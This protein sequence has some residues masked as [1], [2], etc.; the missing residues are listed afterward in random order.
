MQ[1]KNRLIRITENQLKEAESFNFLNGTSEPHCDGQSA[2]SADGRLNDDEYGQPET[3]DDIADTVSPQAYLR[4][5]DKSHGINGIR[6]IWESDEDLNDDG[7]NDFT[8][9]PDKDLLND[10]NFANDITR[11]PPTVI[12]KLNLFLNEIAKHNL[13]ERK[14]YIILSHILK[15]LGLHSLPPS[16]KKDLRNTIN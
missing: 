16:Y 3:T 13:T 12:Q 6:R 2:I 11:I 14:K 1:R 4:Y 5:F 7:A 15:V 9:K 8:Q 10:N